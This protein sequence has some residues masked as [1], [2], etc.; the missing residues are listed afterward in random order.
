[1]LIGVGGRLASN[2]LRVGGRY[3]NSPISGPLVVP[4]CVQAH[5]MAF[6]DGNLLRGG[7]HQQSG[8]LVEGAPRTRPYV[9]DVDQDGPIVALCGLASEALMARLHVADK[10]ARNPIAVGHRYRDQAVN[11]APPP[12]RRP[13]RSSGSS[14]SSFLCSA[15]RQGW[16][17]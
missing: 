16:H 5:T 14:A 17:F 13:K 2:E 6:Q 3:R 15:K 1:L 7:R 10:V 9:A 8:E 4:T 12:S 11:L